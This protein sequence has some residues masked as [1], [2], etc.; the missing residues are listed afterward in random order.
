MAAKVGAD[1][2]EYAKNVPGTH[3]LTLRRGED[4]VEEEP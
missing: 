3:F 1:P 2:V 4:C